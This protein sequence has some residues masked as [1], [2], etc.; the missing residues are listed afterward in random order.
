M[1]LVRV[2][3]SV[4]VIRSAIVLEADDLAKT[5]AVEEIDSG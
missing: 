4:R 1:L 5:L 3:E 2:R